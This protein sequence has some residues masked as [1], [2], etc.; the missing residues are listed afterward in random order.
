MFTLTFNQEQLRIIDQALQNLPYH[1]AAPIINLINAQI[2][3][4]QEAA[5]GN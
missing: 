3:A 4:A 5:D 2:R 1:M